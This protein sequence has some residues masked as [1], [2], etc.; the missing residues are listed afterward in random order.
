[1][2]C[3]VLEQCSGLQKHGGKFDETQHAMLAGMVVGSLYG[4]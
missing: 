3:M 2:H 4:R 1:M